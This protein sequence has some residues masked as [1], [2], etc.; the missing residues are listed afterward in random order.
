MTL[1]LE[2][3]SKTLK[4]KSLAIIPDIEGIKTQFLKYG[5][6][7]FLSIPYS[8]DDLVLRCKKL[9]NC[10]ELNYAVVY[11]RCSVRYEK[12]YNRVMYQNTYIPL[13]STEILIIKLL[14]KNSI[15]S[16][17]QF[18]RYLYSKLGKYYSNEYITILI[19]RTRNKIRLCTGRNL[20][21]NRY[22]CGYYL[23]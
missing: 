15:V 12:R 21:R 5:C 19:H 16:K 17:K 20:I 13:T 18:Q 3:N 6:D 23:V 22:G 10:I 11:E 9:I 2:L 4:T 8:Y 1:L 14:I 7:D